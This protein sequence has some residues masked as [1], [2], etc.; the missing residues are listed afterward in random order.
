MQNLKKLSFLLCAGALLVFTSCGGEETEG[1]DA[2]NTATESVNDSPRNL[3]N[4][5]ASE[6][7]DGEVNMPLENIP[8]NTLGG[9]KLNPPHGAP[10][11]DCAVAVGQPLPSVPGPSLPNVMQPEVNKAA[12]LNP[13]HGAPGH[14]CA[15]EV[16]QPLN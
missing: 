12:N 11:H 14:D 3:P 5:N 10:G 4:M 16:G 8:E 13:P 2:G 7:Q 1:I 9:V 15:V 6:V